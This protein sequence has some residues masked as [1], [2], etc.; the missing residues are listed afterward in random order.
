V[1]AA[2]RAFGGRE[3]SDDLTLVLVRARAEIPN[4]VAV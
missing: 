1:I 2:V 3:Q 4:L